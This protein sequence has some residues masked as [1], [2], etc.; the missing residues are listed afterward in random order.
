MKFTVVIP[1]RYTDR[2]RSAALTFVQDHYLDQGLTIITGDSPSSA[3]SK[4][5]AVNAIVDGF[6]FDGLIVA[7]SDCIV[8]H[9]ALAD[10]M[11]AVAA[12]AAWSMPHRNVLR[13]GRS[14]TYMLYR[15]RRDVSCL[16]AS[17]RPGPPGGGIVVLSRD[18]YDMVGGIDPRFCGWGGEDISFARALDTLVGSCV[19][20]EADL[21]HLWHPKTRRRPG[22]RASPDSE[23]LAGA[24][25]DAEDDPAAM[26]EV[27]AR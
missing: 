17:S 10:S 13:L 12:G 5:A 15:G 4:G 27:I 26:R 1:Y 2:Y 8:T 22:N 20:L 24:Y 14:E 19:R 6:A 11:R 16:R 18:A 9:E 23:R 3:W 21:W 7:D 25:L